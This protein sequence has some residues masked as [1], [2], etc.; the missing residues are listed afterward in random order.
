MTVWVDDRCGDGRV[1][2]E[3]VRLAAEAILEMSGRPGAELSVVLVDDETIRELN[4]RYL[5]RDRPTNVIAFP[6]LEGEG[7][8]VSPDVLGDVVI[9]VDT[10]GREADDGGI[11]IDRRV[12][13]LLVHGFLH[14]L[15]HD[16]IHDE[17]ERARMEK[18]EARLLD[19]LVDR[20]L[21]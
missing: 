1:D 6:M 21:A 18:A 9:S 3:G 20:G 8:D 12:A 7:G 2:P 13:F 16:H 17:E 11:E 15:G 14:L 10:A 5:D 19:A 4:R